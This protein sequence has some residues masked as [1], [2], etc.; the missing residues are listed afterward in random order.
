MLS[1][2]NAW[3]HR[4]IQHG[5]TGVR[6]VPL[7]PSIPYRFAILT[8]AHRPLSLLARE[9]VEMMRSELSAALGPEQDLT[10]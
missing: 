5:G 7:E 2:L 8:P 6:F 10:R 3:I 4:R 1:P 9:F